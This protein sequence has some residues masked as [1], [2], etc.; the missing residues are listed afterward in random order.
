[1]AGVKQWEFSLFG[2]SF[3]NPTLGTNNLLYVPG[4]DGLYAMRTAS[5]LDNSAWPHPLHDAQHTGRATQLPPVPAA[6][7]SLSATMHTRVIDVRLSWPLVVGAAAYEVF[8]STDAMVSNAIFLAEVTGQLV[9]DDKTA[10]VEQ[11]Y[12]YWVRAKN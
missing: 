7:L 10:V 2:V 5:G 11:S 9:Y 12:T 4:S 8:R 6:P 3:G 1:T